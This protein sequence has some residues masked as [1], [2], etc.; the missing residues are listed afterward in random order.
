MHAETPTTRAKGFTL[1]EIMI[2]VAIIV[3][4]VA[5][6]LPAVN[7]LRDSAKADNARA[8][9]QMI[10]MA[11]DEYAGFWPAYSEVRDCTGDGAVDSP[12][13]RAAR[14]LPPWAIKDLWYWDMHLT[15]HLDLFSVGMV[16]DPN[17]ASECLAYCLTAE[18][19]GGPYLK[20]PP[21]GL[22]RYV[23][24]SYPDQSGAETEYQVRRLVDPWGTAYFY[25][26]RASDGALIPWGRHPNGLAGVPDEF[27]WDENVA[28]SFMLMSAGPDRKW[29]YRNPDGTPNHDARGPDNLFGTDDDKLEDDIVF[30]RGG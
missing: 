8:Q 6:L 22:V 12:C 1:T 3:L 10:A 2:V 25:A 11:I 30:G 26:W 4:L 24:I 21:S 23:D 28:Q 9:M 14:G 16:Y 13:V 27:E 7:A 29:C 20:K 5:L 17:R 18:V 19:G 15:R